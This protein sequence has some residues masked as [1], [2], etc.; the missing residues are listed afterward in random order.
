MQGASEMLA[1]QFGFW[2]STKPLDEEEDKIRSLCAHRHDVW[3]SKVSR[4]A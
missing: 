4:A 2:I 3:L 1:E